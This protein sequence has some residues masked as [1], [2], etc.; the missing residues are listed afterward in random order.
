[1]LM[2]KGFGLVILI[3]AIVMNVIICRW[4][5]RASLSIVKYKHQPKSTISIVTKQR[6]NETLY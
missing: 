3:M 4:E 6:G 5:N 1:M 2:A